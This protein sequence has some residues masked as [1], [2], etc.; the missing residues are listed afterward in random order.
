MFFSTFQQVE[1]DDNL[2]TF[3]LNLLIIELLYFLAISNMALPFYNTLVTFH[4]ESIL[5]LVIQVWLTIG[6]NDLVVILI[7]HKHLLPLSYSSFF[8]MKLVLVQIYSLFM[9]DFQ[10]LKIW[11]LKLSN[12]GSHIGKHLLQSFWNEETPKGLPKT[13]HVQLLLNHGNYRAIAS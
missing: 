12:L 9:Q 10:F 5:C 11:F 1:I 7:E 6:C 3:F 13:H 2:C 8:F 4:F